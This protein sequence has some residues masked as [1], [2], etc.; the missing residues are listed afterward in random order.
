[1]AS[2][3]AGQLP[4]MCDVC[5]MRYTCYVLELHVCILMICLGV[6]DIQE[7]QANVQLWVLLSGRIQRQNFFLL[8]AF[9]IFFLVVAIQN[10]IDARHPWRWGSASL[11]KM[12]FCF[13]LFL[14]QASL[15]PEN[16]ASWICESLTALE[17]LFC[18]PSL[19]R[20]GNK[21]TTS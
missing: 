7:S 10:T 13:V 14:T 6:L 12:Y 19:A 17:E 2:P 9:S 3:C 5:R 4:C 11:W 21:R 18:T 15:L 1:M 16:V 8:C 20:V